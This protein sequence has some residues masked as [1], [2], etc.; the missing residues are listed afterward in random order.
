MV[1]SHVFAAMHA[2]TELQFRRLVWSHKRLFFRLL[3]FALSQ[4]RIRGNLRIGFI[5][6]I[7]NP[8]PN[9]EAMMPATEKASCDYCGIA[10]YFA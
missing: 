5:P 2:Q 3:F 1:T 8:F 7:L 9:Q 10:P 6:P 4:L